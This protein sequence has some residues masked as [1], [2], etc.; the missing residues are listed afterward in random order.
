MIQFWNM[1]DQ[2]C[3]FQVYFSLVTLRHLHDH[4]PD[5]LPDPVHLLHFVNA[6]PF[7]KSSL[8]NMGIIWKVLDRVFQLY[9]R[10]TSYLTPL[11]IKKN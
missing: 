10:Q 8:D 7:K 4:H 11:P 2:M 5:F 6:V 1:L 9:Q 3:P